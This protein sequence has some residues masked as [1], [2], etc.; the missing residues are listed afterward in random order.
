[1]AEESLKRG[2]TV[3]V[4]TN[5]HMGDLNGVRVTS[6]SNILD[7]PFDLIIVH[8][9]GCNNQNQV[10]V[11][12]DFIKSKIL[13]LI[14]LPSTNSICMKGL[15]NATFLG[16]STKADFDHCIKYRHDLKIK[17]VRHGIKIP[18]ID[19]SI[20]QTFRE[21]YNIT[22]KYMI[23]TCGGF[24]S[25]KNMIELA[26][27]VDELKLHDTTLV[28]TG[29]HNNNTHRPRDSQFV[30][31]FFIEDRNEVIQAVHEADLY[32]MNS[33]EEGFGLVL[34]EAMA[35]R[36]PWIARGVAGALELQKYG[37]VYYDRTELAPLLSNLENTISRI[38]T[39]AA[40]EY[41]TSNHLIQNTVDDILSCIV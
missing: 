11:R 18:K 4:F 29:Y 9:G 28:C 1:M 25:H 7:E 30:K 31:S 16:C 37:I 2:Y 27:V 38:D 8:G 12:S 33:Y 3:S 23:L 15:A 5:D 6:D 41:V 32:V 36:T 24:W 14:I 17:R 21:H 35:L 13:Y 34:L 39:Q 19:A 26:W 22:T 40:Y 20:K 10:H